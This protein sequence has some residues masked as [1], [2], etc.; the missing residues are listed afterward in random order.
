MS[1]DAF[2]YVLLRHPKLYYSRPH[3]I[4]NNILIT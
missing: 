4:N 1:K 2:F 3:R